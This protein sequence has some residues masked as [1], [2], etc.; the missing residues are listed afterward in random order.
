VTTRIVYDFMN[1]HPFGWIVAAYFF[2]A[3]VAS[4]LAIFTMAVHLFKLTKYQRL[5]R[6]TAFVTPFIAAL[7]ALTLIAELAQPMRFFRVLFNFNPASPIS[8]GTWI[9]NLFAL[10]SVAYAYAELKGLTA[11]KRPLAIIGVPIAALLPMYTAFELLMTRAST[12]WTSSLLPV[13]YLLSAGVAGIAVVLFISAVTRPD[14]I[15]NVTFW[16]GRIGSHFV[17]Y[18]FALMVIQV[19]VLFSRSTPAAVIGHSLISGYYSAAFW[20]VLFVGGTVLPVG[21]LYFPTTG[22]T[23]VGQIVA[24]LLI[25][26]GVFSQRALEIFAG[27]NFPH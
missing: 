25:L 15:A 6:I 4:G 5:A 20:G 13:I 9:L 21:L 19:L 24:S 17:I 1:E 12:L 26:A 3:S 7:V 11:Y 2:A 22:R 27:M 18:A 8:W 14:P 10:I 23:R 16:L